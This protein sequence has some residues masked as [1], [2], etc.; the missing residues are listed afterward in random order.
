MNK[1]C[2]LELGR[3]QG[4]ITAKE[5]HD[6]SGKVA[7]NLTQIQTGYF[8]NTSVQCYSK[9]TVPNFTFVPLIHSM[10]TSSE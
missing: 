10:I 7:S 8:K 4:T 5:N 1:N 6:K 2:M 3:S 9:K